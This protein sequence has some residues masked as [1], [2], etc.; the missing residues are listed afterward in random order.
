MVFDN[1]SAFLKAGFG[2]D[3]Q[4]RAVF[5][6][7]VGR[8]RADPTDICIA[9]DA[10]SRRGVT[11][12]YPVEH[13]VVAHWD[14]MERIWRRG[15]ADIQANPHDHAMLL[16]E[17]PMNPKGNRE[18]SA[19]V[20]FESIGVPAMHLSIQAVL[21]LYSGGRTEG[22]VLD[23]GDG[24]T[25]TV[26]VY[27]GHA[28]ISAIRRMDVA[29]RDIT[30]WVMQLLSDEC[31]RPFTTS[32]DREL[33]RQFKEKH[34]YVAEDF[35]AEQAAIETGKKAKTTFTLPDGQVLQCGI[36]CPGGPELLF[37]PPV[38]E[39]SDLP[40]HKVAF[41]SIQE[42]GIDVRRPLLHNIVLS[43]GT[44][45]FPGF[46]ER[47]RREMVELAP[48]R[49]KD[50][51]RVV[52]LAERKYSVWMG[53]AILASLQTFSTEWFTKQEWQE[54]GPNALHRRCEG[55]SFVDK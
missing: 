17:P 2:G 1:G 6:S 53:A 22:L 21:A 20:M 28:T 52:A 12:R 14:D 24:V 37:D 48:P 23:S 50:D 4:P 42:C 7:V 9:D 27:D 10:L 31:D 46:A 13:G 49:A 26:P 34:C 45:M 18:K 36:S 29:G 19:E 41:S 47:L 35:A 30:E 11:L 32:A 39:K 55:L 40:V 3:E 5:P 8:S 51:V 43:G 54:G 15:F 33:A 25:H 16:T 38:A 44:T